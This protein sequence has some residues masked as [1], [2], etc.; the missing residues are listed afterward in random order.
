MWERW[1]KKYIN[2]QAIIEGIE[3]RIMSAAPKNDYVKHKFKRTLT[4]LEIMRRGKN[5]TSR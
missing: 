3:D 4:R 2:V 1:P 5:A